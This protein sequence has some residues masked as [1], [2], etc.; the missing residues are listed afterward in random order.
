MTELINRKHCLNHIQQAIY[1]TLEAQRKHH[2]DQYK[3]GAI[4]GALQELLR[5]KNYVLTAKHEST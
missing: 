4:D 5:I 3:K 2:T 1:F